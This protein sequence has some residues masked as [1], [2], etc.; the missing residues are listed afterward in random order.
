VSSSGRRIF[1]RRNRDD[2]RTFNVADDGARKV[3]PRR[4]IA[5]TEV[6]QPAAFHER[7]HALADDPCDRFRQVAAP[8]GNAELIGDDTQLFALGLREPPISVITRRK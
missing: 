6:I 3:V 4:S 7:R 1:R 5:G 8:V 2:S